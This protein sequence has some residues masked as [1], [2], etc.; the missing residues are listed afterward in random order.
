MKEIHGWECAF[1]TDT[2]KILACPAA[3]AFKPSTKIDGQSVSDLLKGFF[4]F[5]ASFRFSDS[6]SNNYLLV[7]THVGKVQPVAKDSIQQLTKL[8]E[9]VNVQDPFDLSHNLTGNIGPATLDRFVTECRASAELLVYGQAPQASKSLVPKAWGLALLM[10]KKALPILIPAF[11]NNAAGI[12]HHELVTE[13]KQ[14]FILFLLEE[15]LKMERLSG[16]DDID[17]MLILKRKKPLRVLNQICDQVDSL[18]INSGASQTYSPKRLRVQ[19]SGSTHTD[20]VMLS[21]RE[22]QLLEQER[23]QE[24][25]DNNNNNEKLLGLFQFT[26]RFNTWQGRRPIKRELKTKCKSDEVEL[27][28]WTSESLIEEQQKEA[29]SFKPITFTVQFV[30]CDNTPE[31]LKVKFDLWNTLVASDESESDER[32][33]RECVQFTTLVHFLDVYISNGQEKLFPSW[34]SKITSAV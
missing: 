23:E 21:D 24:I 29:Q 6:A 7:S 11:D 33:I 32:N 2:A 20:C 27:E 12:T 28:K 17:K 3:L 31:K 15:C 16:G 8:S 18:G 26:A 13:S 25:N 1:E 30:T 5:Y 14:S 19:N 34:T 9:H 22:Q 4:E 10:T